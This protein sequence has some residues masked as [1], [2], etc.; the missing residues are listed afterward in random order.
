MTGTDIAGALL[1]VRASVDSLPPWSARRWRAELGL[2]LL[3]LGAVL[4]HQGGRLLLAA[5][6]IGNVNGIG[7]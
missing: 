3:R 4:T 1:S 2:A 5:A 6:N 7:R